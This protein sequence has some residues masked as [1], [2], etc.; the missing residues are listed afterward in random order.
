[1]LV[2]PNFLSA[3]AGTTI[4]GTAVADYTSFQNLQNMVFSLSTNVHDSQKITDSCTSKCSLLLLYPDTMTD[5]KIDR[6]L[7][8]VKMPSNRLGTNLTQIAVKKL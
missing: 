5:R 8:L 1:M 6:Q 3:I 4:A 7:K 2:L